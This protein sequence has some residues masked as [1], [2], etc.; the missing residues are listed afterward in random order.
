[1][2]LL[3]VLLPIRAKHSGT[4]EGLNEASRLGRTKYV[5]H[6]LFIH[7]ERMQ[8]NGDLQEFEYNT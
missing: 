6:T 5:T 1:M 8:V 7:P 2:L 3:T 4:K